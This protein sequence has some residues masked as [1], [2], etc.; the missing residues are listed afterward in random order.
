M[1]LSTRL[2][3]AFIITL[4]GGASACF[5]KDTTAVELEFFEKKV[6]PVLATHCYKCHGPKKQKGAL[7][8]DSRAGLITGGDTGKAIVPGQPDESLLI[9]SI[10]YGDDGYQM[11]PSGK[12]PATAIDDLT[13]WVKMGAPWPAEEVPD[14]TTDNGFDLAER[15][16]HWSFQP[17]Q[18][19][20][21]P[22]VQNS[23]WP[24]TTE[25]RYIL[26]A[27]EQQG[28]K[29]AG[30]A[31]R[32]VLIR[33]LSFAILGLPPTPVEVEAFL[34]DDAPQ[35]TERLVDRLLAAPQFGER[36]G[37]HWLD[38]V[39]YAESH[40]HEFD[41]PIHHA[42]RYRDYV[43]RALNADIPYDD[44]VRE[45]IA[46]DLLPHPRMHPEE[47][48]NESILGT[49]FWYLGEATH[50]PVDVRGD[51]AGRI[52]NQIDVM[53]KSFLGITVACA[54]C[55]DHKFD[56][57]TTA[58][59]YALAGFLQSSRK[60]V[61]LLDPHGKVANAAAKL[62]QLR[63]SANA[64]FVTVVPQPSDDAA[65]DF[66]AYLGAAIAFSHT[67]SGSKAATF[68]QERGLDPA[69]LSRWIET[70]K[71]TDNDQPAQPDFLFKSLVKS[72]QNKPQPAFIAWKQDVI[73]ELATA[74]KTAD[75]TFANTELLADFDSGDYGDWFVTGAAFGAGPTQAQDSDATSPVAAPAPAG[76]AHSGQLAGKLQGV[77][78]S[79]TFTITGNQVFY[80]MAGRG[81][82]I[83]LIIDG[84]YMNEFSGLLFRDMKFDV[85]TDGRYVWRTQKVGKYLGHKAYIELI[86]D[87]DGFVAVD[88]IRIGN[89]QPQP[90]D[91][92]D[93]AFFEFLKDET[94]DS[95]EALSTA[96]GERWRTA[97]SKWQAG[98]A[99]AYDLQLLQ[100][101]MARQLI[102]LPDSEFAAMTKRWQEL[103]DAIPAPMKALALTA[104]SPEDE[105]IHIRGSHKKLGKVAQRRFLEVLAGPDQ[106]PI[107]NACGRLE[108]AEQIVD[109]TNP[110]T[111]R[112]IVNRVWHHLFG[113]GIVASVDNFGVLGQP[114]THPELL[115]HLA[116]EFIA[117][118]WSIKRL[119]RRL[120]LS[121]TYQMSSHVT[122]PAA[123][124]TDPENLLLH[125]MRM[126]RLEGEAIRDAI[127]LISG[128]LDSRHFGNSTPVHL[129]RF[130]EGRGRPKKDGPLDGDGRRSIYI[131]VNR[132]FLS[133]MMLAFDTP[134]P[135]STVG[136]RSESNVPAQALILMN[137]PFVK[138]QAELWA[139]RLIDA[140]GDRTQRIQTMYQQAYARPP[141]AVEIEAAEAFLISQATAYDIAGEEARNDPRV[142]ADLCHVLITLKEF[143]FVE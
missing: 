34:N 59:Y 51:E 18:K 133:P 80:R 140:E 43:I 116:T 44:F 16:K 22:S 115:D 104:G 123:E 47:E 8:L 35:A 89:S 61:A 97:L 78:R 67:T 3:L 76:V 6:R 55:H 114:P 92:P 58:D 142:W 91:T 19:S 120:V 79:P 28:L 113:R 121:R 134:I 5:A 53:T 117:D 122:D 108:L 81:G 102:D 10:R 63:N 137:D 74:A 125:R 36:W 138:Q 11:P 94:L 50:A 106:P 69:R 71:P 85:K 130:M 20:A 111:A 15:A 12:L 105:R 49:G 9:E 17:L 87:G 4:C 64:E 70:V 54:R 90:Q 124:E 82:R 65:T 29:P 57:I 132:N 136:R 109:A 73:A 83:R 98:E 14:S 56:P 46:G 60:D 101:V 75:D 84:Y 45:H 100:W 62:S 77:L 38:L 131:R 33:R 110:L 99:D 31:S 48:Y 143:T 68:A 41:F 139:K 32:R 118:G 37:R 126:H 128:R 21:P 39:R 96:A 42:W 93:P 129:T 26:A 95:T 24:R 107:L 103:A 52:D 1:K 88:E 27:L 25:D 2:V 72:L 30:D 66:A 127:L 86:D 141:S 7:R 13:K 40:G 112:V 23:V 135:F 119:I